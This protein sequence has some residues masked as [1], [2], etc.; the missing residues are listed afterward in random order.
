[1]TNARGKD[2]DEANISSWLGDTNGA[3]VKIPIKTFLFGEKGMDNPD[4]KAD[5]DGYNLATDQQANNNK[6]F[7]D[8]T[9]RIRRFQ[10]IQKNIIKVMM[11][12]VNKDLKKLNGVIV[13]TFTKK[14]IIL[15]QNILIL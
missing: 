11:K 7:I 9:L 13:K 6:T 4:Y 1:M 5:L 8:I 2:S 3:A 15:Q 14:I 12:C 10:G